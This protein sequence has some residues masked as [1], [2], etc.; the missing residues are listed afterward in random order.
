MDDAGASYV[1]NYPSPLSLPDQQPCC[2]PPPSLLPG[3]RTGGLAVVGQTA[4]LGPVT[5]GA[6]A[7]LG[8]SR[9]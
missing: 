6:W 7:V 4:Q 8:H 2:G 3:L 5:V 9:T 1:A